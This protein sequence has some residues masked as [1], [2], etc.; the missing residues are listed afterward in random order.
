[1]LETLPTKDT[2]IEGAREA[3]DYLPISLDLWLVSV[4]NTIQSGLHSPPPHK[5]NDRIAITLAANS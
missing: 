5:T 3:N 1:M 2:S 4:P